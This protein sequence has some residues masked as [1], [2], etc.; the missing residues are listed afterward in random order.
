MLVRIVTKK[1][2]RI[3][4]PPCIRFAYETFGLGLP[5]RHYK[6]ATEYNKLPAEDL[7]AV[8]SVIDLPSTLTPSAELGPGA[9]TPTSPRRSSSYL[10]PDGT[11][12]PRSAVSSAESSRAPSPNPLH[13]RDRVRIEH[14]LTNGTG[15]DGS[16]SPTQ[17][18]RIAEQ[19]AEALSKK[20]EK[21][22]RDSHDD[23]KRYDA[24]GE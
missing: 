2:C 8:P 3:I 19:L 5:R 17:V 16:G 10:S 22:R 18:D 14:V 24:E 6:P 11:V 12:R 20:K 15:K 13:N 21:S 9:K 1:L 4:L 7:R 23:A